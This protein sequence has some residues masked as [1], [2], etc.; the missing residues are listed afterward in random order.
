MS[1]DPS[2]LLKIPVSTWSV[3]KSVLL[4]GCTA[5]R[6][7]CTPWLLS[8]PRGSIHGEQL[9]PK[10]LTLL[11]WKVAELHSRSAPNNVFAYCVN[12]CVY[13]YTHPKFYECSKVKVNNFSDCSGVPWNSIIG[14]GMPSALGLVHMI[15][16]S[17]YT[18]HQNVLSCVNQVFPSVNWIMMEFDKYFQ[19]IFEPCTS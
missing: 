2:K 6:K 3:V 8:N 11:L 4:R 14:S 13:V 18:I 16:V 19:N 9:E 12:T 10:R 1:G 5:G 17:K 15:L 7:I